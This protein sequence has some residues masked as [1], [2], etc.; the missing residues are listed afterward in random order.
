MSTAFFSERVTDATYVGKV[1]LYLALGLMFTG[2]CAYGAVSYG[3]P[4]P[5]EFKDH[6]LLLPPAVAFVCNHMIVSSLALFATVILAAIVRHLEV[7][8]V[9]AYAF[10]CAV[11][12]I[13]IGPSIFIAQLEAST[14]NTFSANPV[15]DAFALTVAG[16][17]GMSLYAL[18][19]KRDFS[20]WSGAL[21]GGLIVVIVA[22]FIG[23]FL[24]STV[25]SLAVC[26]V[27]VI[28]FLG[29]VAFDTGKILRK[30]YGEDAVGDA[31]NLHLDF[32]NIFLNLLRLLSASKD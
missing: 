5:I 2:L 28:L 13:F 24:G 1:Y 25:F 11:T 4:V 10:F 16:V 23:M 29:F 8:N 19:S 21:W 31:M 12:G 3:T 6:T 9:L 17:G 32:L 18:F 22:G 30:T 27:S 14:G 20:A 26:S 7:A 15:R